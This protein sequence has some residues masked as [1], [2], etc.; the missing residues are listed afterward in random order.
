MTEDELKALVSA[1]Q[2]E[3]GDLLLF[4]AD[5]NKIVWNV[6]GAVSYTHLICRNKCNSATVCT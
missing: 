4:A 3:P 1:M 6:L 2:G 5:K